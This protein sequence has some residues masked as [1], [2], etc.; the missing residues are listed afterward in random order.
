MNLNTFTQI[1]HHITTWYYMGIWI[2][3][4]GVLQSRISSCDRY[5]GALTIIMSSRCMVSGNNRLFRYSSHGMVGKLSCRSA[6]FIG[7]YSLAVSRRSSADIDI[8]ANRISN[9]NECLSS[10]TALC[11]SA[12]NS[13]AMSTMY[14]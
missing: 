5:F 4:L 8:L 14:L 2:Y 3:L 1:L 13:T 9:S 6:S 12:P 7:L 10:L 11:R